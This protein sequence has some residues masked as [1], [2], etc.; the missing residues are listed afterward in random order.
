MQS[1]IDHYESY[2]KA[3][4]SFDLWIGNGRILLFPS[5]QELQSNWTTLRDG[6]IWLPRTPDFSKSWST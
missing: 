3:D 1:L 5:L 4:L 2:Q 6:K